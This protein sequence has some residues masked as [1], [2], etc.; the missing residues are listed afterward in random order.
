VRFDLEGKELNFFTNSFRISLR[1]NKSDMKRAMEYKGCITEIKDVTQSGLVIFYASVFGN[2]DLG[3]DIIEAGAFKKTLKENQKNIRHFK[4]HNPKLMPGVIQELK[5]DDYGLL[6]TSKL[7]LSTQLGKETYEEYKAMAEAGK[8]MDHSIGY[9]TIKY[10]DDQTTQTRKLKEIRLFEVST[11][12]EWGMN[13][14]AQTVNV[15]SI[16][17]LLKEHKYFELLLKCNFTDAKLNEL[18]QFKAHLESLI[19]SRQKIDTPT[20]EPIS[21]TEFINNLKFF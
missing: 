15:K 5:E 7:I 20:L 4:H 3:G 12:T 21:A 19:A 14:L 18:E 8:S 11:L 13:P 1:L 10:E 6:A 2:T 17:E 16:D 9:S